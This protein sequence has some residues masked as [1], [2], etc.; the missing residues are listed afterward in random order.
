MSRFS[1]RWFIFIA[2]VLGLGAILLLCVPKGANAGGGTLNNFGGLIKYH[3]NAY[4]DVYNNGRFSYAGFTMMQLWSNVREATSVVKY[5]SSGVQSYNPIWRPSSSHYVA[6]YPRSESERDEAEAVI[7]VD[8][9]DR[10]SGITLGTRW[11]QVCPDSVGFSIY[12]DAAG[13]IWTSVHSDEHNSRKLRVSSLNNG[14]SQEVTPAHSY[15][16][17]GLVA[18]MLHVYSL[19]GTLCG[20]FWWDQLVQPGVIYPTAQFFMPNVGRGR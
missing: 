4:N 2:S 17:R 5:T 9:V 13:T 3:T 7:G 20:S 1:V 15:G 18:G 6:D 12:T 16:T 8:V 14:D 10:L 11:S 19:S